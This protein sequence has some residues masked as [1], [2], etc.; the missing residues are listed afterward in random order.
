MVDYS[1][2]AIVIP[3]LGRHDFLVRTIQYYSGL[4]LSLNL[5]I[6]DSSPEPLALPGPLVDSLSRSNLNYFYFHLPGLNDRQAIS[7]LVD[8]VCGHEIEFISFHGDDDYFVPEALLDCSS[9]LSRNLDYTSA[10]GSAVHFS[11]SSWTIWC[12]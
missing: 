6:G 10:Q 12:P 7:Y 3:S 5:F 8:E 9:F 2:I 1:S 4:N 11:E